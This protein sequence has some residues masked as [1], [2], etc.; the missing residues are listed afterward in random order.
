MVLGTPDWEETARFYIDTFGFIPSDVQALPDGRPA[1][2]FMRCDRGEEVT[3]HHTFV[4][5][6]LPVVHLEHAAFEVPDLD[7]EIS[8]I[9]P[10]AFKA[11]IG[12]VTQAF[13]NLKVVATTL[14]NAKTAS[15]NDWG[16]V[17]WTD[18]AFHEARMRE[19]LDIYDRVGGGDGFATGLAWSFLD[20]R[21]AQEAVEIGAAHGA[22]TMTTPGDTSMMTKA[23][24]LRAVTAKGARVVR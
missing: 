20:G 3:D 1:V 13:P 18:G 19:D 2:A 9:D 24:V 11:M 10:A 17:L 7:H 21:D 14:R 4:V 5:A 12:Q 8:K 15:V 23:E 6:R 22:L 16:A